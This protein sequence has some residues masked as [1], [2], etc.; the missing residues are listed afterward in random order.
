M[1]TDTKTGWVVV[2][3]TWFAKATWHWNV[4]EQKLKTKIPNKPQAQ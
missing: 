3:V 2:G 4:K 1:L